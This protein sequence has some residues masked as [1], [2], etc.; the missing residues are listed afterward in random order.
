VATDSVRVQVSG[1]IYGLTL[2]D[3]TDY[4][5]W[6][7]VFRATEG[8]AVLKMN[9]GYPSGVTKDKFNTGYSYNYTVGT[10]NQYGIATGRIDKY[11]LPLVNGSHPKFTNVGV[12]KTGY[13]V[14][15]KLTT[16]GNA[17]SSGDSVVIRPKFYYVDDQGKNRQEVDIY[18]TE[19]FKG[20][21][22]N[23]VK[24]G[25]ALDLT[26][27]KNYECG[28]QY[29]GIPKA[30]LQMIAD[31]RKMALSK[32]LWEDT[33]L[34]TY[35]NIRIRTPL[36]TYVN[37]DYLRSIKAGAQYDAIIAAGVKEVD[38]VKRMQ[39]FYAEYFFPADV[40]AVKKGYDVYG[41]ASKYGVKKDEAF[42]LSGGYIII[43]FDIVTE[44]KDGN[45]NLSYVNETNEA[46]GYC[47][48]WDMEKPVTTKQSYNGKKKKSTIFD[49]LPGDFMVYFTDLSLKDDYVTYIIN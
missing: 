12:L 21:S 9:A 23:L 27:I 28:E 46:K 4:P 40:K 15:F 42:W 35:T 33:D 44:D 47:S 14:K 37:T 30:E 38:I 36:M 48:M 24:M 49:F 17:F 1:R 39:S 41:Y 19:N 2:Y 11:T 16:T 7:T 20:K 3:V 25:S 26:N 32:Y 43:N 34:F 13:A 8:S 10:S 6:E 29:F 18:Y 45:K 5:T 31:I 22:H